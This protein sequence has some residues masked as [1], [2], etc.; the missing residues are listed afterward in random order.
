MTFWE[1]FFIA[2]FS[3]G[4]AGAVIRYLLDTKKQQYENTLKLHETWWNSDFS[5]YRDEI[6]EIIKDLE[7]PE[8][9][10]KLSSEFLRCVA[11][12]NATSHPAWNSFKRIVVF[13]A[14]LNVWIEKGLIDR[15]LAYRMFGEAQ[16]Y[17]FKPLIDEVRPHVGQ[18]I[19][20]RWMK[21]VSKL[22]EKFRKFKSK[23]EASRQKV[24]RAAA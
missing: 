15:A 19:G 17:W 14:D 2:T 9:A 20:V 24:P 11:D 18:R 16:Y 3:G 5:K 21:D 10:R 22:E 4:A 13:F 6:F 23:D 12:G 1:T 7:G 8:E